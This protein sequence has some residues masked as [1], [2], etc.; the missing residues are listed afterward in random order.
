M[1]AGMFGMGRR[2]ASI[3]RSG[4]M[5]ACKHARIYKRQFNAEAAATLKQSGLP[6][7]LPHSEQIT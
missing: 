2:V 5:I 4:Q 1:T 6:L 7:S 3:D